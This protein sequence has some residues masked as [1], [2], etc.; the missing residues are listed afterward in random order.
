MPNP[1][2]YNYCKWNST[3][4]GTG[5]F[6][7]GTAAADDSA[8]PHATPANCYAINGETYRYYARTSNGL[9]WEVGKGV[10]NAGTLTR[11]T[12]TENSNNNTSAVNFSANPIVDVFPKP[13]Q[14]IERPGGFTA[15]TL[16]LFQQTSAPFGWTK[17]TTHNDKALRVVSGTAGSGGTNAFSTMFASRTSDATTLSSTQM[18][19]HQHSD[20]YTWWTITSNAVQRTGG[21][22]DDLT[23]FSTVTGA[24]GGG[25]SHT[26]TYDMRVQYVDLIIA[27]KN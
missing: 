3:T 23:T 26:H 2:F 14:S 21:V 24:A 16:M 12:I 22:G 5:T 8:G 11:A 17:Q 1:E 20:T 6:T 7:V 25:G 19:N 10:Y 4:A 13:E 9:Q 15:G 27:A 18:P